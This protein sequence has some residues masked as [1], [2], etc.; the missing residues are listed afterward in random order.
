[1]IIELV[2]MVTIILTILHINVI[3]DRIF[4]CERI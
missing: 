2:L 4:K 1:M 3:N